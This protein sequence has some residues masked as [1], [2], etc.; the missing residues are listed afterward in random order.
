NM[1]LTGLL[2]SMLLLVL[3]MP[4]QMALAQYWWN[5]EAVLQGFMTPYFTPVPNSRFTH[6]PYITSLSPNEYDVIVNVPK[7]GMG[8]YIGHSGWVDY[9]Y[10]WTQWPAP[11]GRFVNYFLGIP[12]AAPPVNDQRFR[13]PR[14]AFLD[15]RHA[16]QAKR[17]RS[18]CMQNPAYM[19]ERIPGF[20]DFNEDCLYL[21]LFY[22]NN[23]YEPQTMLYPV[24]IFIHGGDFAHGSAHLYPGH[25]LASQ[26]AVVVTFNYR[27]GVFG[28]LSTGDFASTGNYGLWDQIEAM[29]W[30]RD[31]IR[32]FRG[33]P[34]SVT[35]TGEGSGADSV[36]IHLVSP[37]SREL[38][39]FHRVAL[40]SGSDLGAWSVANPLL[41]RT[42]DYAKEL[43]KR[44]G[45]ST[46]DTYYMVYCI[47]YLHPDSAA[48]LSAASA[49]KPHHP[50]SPYVWTPVVDGEVGLIPREPVVE[51][52]QGRFA[53]PPAIMGFTHD[54]LAKD[55]DRRLREWGITPLSSGADFT[56]SD[57]AKAIEKFLDYLK[58]R[59]M[60]DT[61]EE[62]FFRYNW[63]SQPD[64][65]TARREQFIALISDW[66]VRSGLDYA[67]KMHSQRQ[68][69]TYAYEFAY[70]G[71]NDSTPK[72]LGIYQG[73]TSQ[74][75]FGLPF[76]N[77][78]WWRELL[79]PQP[80]PTLFPWDRIL[81]YNMSEFVM[82]MWV[83][84]MRYENP[85]PYENRN[86]SW[87]PY[88]LHEQSY[89]HLFINASNRRA[90]R[91]NQMAFWRQR[92]GLVAEP[93]EPV[94][95]EFPYPLYEAQIATYVLGIVLFICLIALVGIIVL[96]VRTQRYDPD[97]YVPP[98]DAFS[99]AF[100]QDFIS[101]KNESQI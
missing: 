87:L 42:M 25:A 5:W 81:D 11:K 93:I 16:W 23:T 33:D 19:Q 54:E 63:W 28:F 60:N 30:V 74:F 53:A 92:Y 14:P 9:D 67:I 64:N 6:T 48:M 35:L 100:R 10:T 88:T 79:T 77:T 83:N 58:V 80:P 20:N 12:Y 56:D 70:R 90:Y 43:A 51:R 24:L 71:L 32:Y 34:S 69:I 96:L 37:V 18:A 94:P 73:T 50:A 72:A 61:Y 17:Y 15:V 86:F 39:L 97:T 82:Q 40:M 47:R 29:K 2:G 8:A 59:H 99:D 1:T 45:C 36:G 66:G 78:S 38:G 89:A 62:V 95:T 31:N 52:S 75:L 84:F 27:L 7:A 101:A 41:V 22:P 21:N 3:A 68:P 26:G 91:P 44:L 65:M 49:V 76:M 13:I 57:F 4:L 98:E 85:T 55:A 46:R